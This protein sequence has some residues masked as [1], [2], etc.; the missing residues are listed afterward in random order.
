MTPLDDEKSLVDGLLDE[1][2]GQSRPT[3]IT[4][5]LL[6]KKRFSPERLAE[7]DAAMNAARSDIRSVRIQPRSAASYRKRRRRYS[8]LFV[9]ATM[10]ASLLAI[11]GGWFAFSHRDKF[12]LNAFESI[13]KTDLPQASGAKPPMEQK[14]P[15]L[16]PAPETIV[17][18]STVASST[19]S[20]VETP[21]TA[22]PRE[23]LFS[24]ATPFETPKETTIAAEIPKALTKVPK[25]S[26]SEIVKS[27]DD[28]LNGLW[29]KYQVQPSAP[30][31]DAEWIARATKHLLN[32]QPTQSEQE[33]FVRKDSHVARAS[34]LNETIKGS[35]IARHWGKN[36]ALFYLGEQVGFNREV[37]E[38]RQE[39]IKWFQGELLQSNRL[40]SMAYKVVVLDTTPSA[41]S[42]DFS[43]SR[44]WWSKMRN[45]SQHAAVDILDT[46]LL[47]GV[48][49]CSRCHDSGT[50]GT[51]DQT[52]YWNL[53][54][55]TQGVSIAKNAD[56]SIGI[57]SYRSVAEPLYYERENASL[58]AAVPTIPNGRILEGLSG[59][60]SQVKSVARKNL[61]EFG[62]WLVTSEQ[63][64]QGQ[65]D[66]AW[67]VVFGQPLLGRW[68]G[69][70]ED[71]QAEREALAHALAQQLIA[72]DFDLAA[73]VTWLAKSQGFQRRAADLDAN[74]Y[75]SAGDSDLRNASRRTQ[76]LGV[77]PAARSQNLRLMSRVVQLTEIFVPKTVEQTAV[78]ANPLLPKNPSK[79]IASQPLK[80]SSPKDTRLTPQQVEYLTRVY[81][82]PKSMELQLDRI[83]KSKLT[84]HQMVEHAFLMTGI[85]PPNANELAAA[86]QILDW[87][88]DRRQTLHRIL[89]AR[90]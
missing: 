15:S 64:A 57:A 73:L 49:S 46:R 77:F 68:P 51:A 70:T 85:E 6:K 8:G 9:L 23:S 79:A 80:T 3:V 40:D 21:K 65:V 28:H 84:W 11:A 39:F 26:E 54:A 63:F 52:S 72:H 87:T 30:V 66:F 18:S 60:A 42:S 16:R 2:L 56:G 78:L 61:K 43:A 53:A 86:D 5:Q 50:V 34:W 41:S 89:A 35:E 71:G 19:P 88:R 1:W 20:N 36:L 58:V 76:M 13:A 29:T 22:S 7:L 81:A 17:A 83:L 37:N 31:N 59:D 45:L 82:L 24:T 38:T 4:P 25:R 14:A 62:R 75:L 55:I 67:Q 90:M 33:L 47:G 69:T 27:I 74:W 10:A 32:R 48:G 44:F 12:Q